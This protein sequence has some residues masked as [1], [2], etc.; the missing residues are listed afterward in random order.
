M[1]KNRAIGHDLAV[2]PND[3][4]EKIR[5]QFDTL[6]YPDAPLNTS[7]QGKSDFLFIHNLITPYY[8]RYQRIVDPKGKLILDAGC[9]SGYKALALAVANPG[10]TI[11]GIDLSAESVKL[12]EQRLRYHG[13]T[14]SEFH[15]LPLE[16]LPSLGMSFDYINCDEVM[17]VLP[18]VAL[19]LKSLQAVL[20]PEGIIRGNLHSALQRKNY[21][22]A[23][24]LFAMMNLM[25]DNPEELEMTIARETMTA[26]KPEVHLRQFTWNEERGQT[27]H[28]ILMNYLYQGDRGYTIPQL[29]A[30]LRAADL[31]FISMVDWRKWELLDL[32]KNPDD[33]PAFWAMSLPELS[34]EERLTLFELI[35]PVNRLLDFWCG[36]P[37]SEP[38]PPPVIEWSVEDWHGAIVSLHPQLRTEKA[39]EGLQRCIAEKVSFCM[40]EYLRHPTLKDVNLESGMA[41]MLLPLWDAP[42]AIETLVSHWQRL[43]PVHPVTLEPTSWELAFEQVTQFLTRLETNLYVLIEACQG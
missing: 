34:A 6:P 18:D 31:E 32:F 19:G 40:S 25:D 36:H 9:G 7:P 30:A 14:N 23:Q 29:F 13:I 41:A 42:Q 43:K 16:E 26:L 5:Q 1:D 39:R 24:Q 37:Q 22:A 35:Q 27:D 21:Y 12:A 33:L 11:V 2:L 10:A 8:L 28:F 20:K 38:T 3:I 4:Q 15:Q 17:S